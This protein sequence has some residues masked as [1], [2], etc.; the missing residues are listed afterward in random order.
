VVPAYIGRRAPGGLARSGGF[1][2]TGSLEAGADAPSGLPGFLVPGRENER[3]RTTLLSTDTACVS[4]W[5]WD[6]IF[7]SMKDSAFRPSGAFQCRDFLFGKRDLDRYTQHERTR[8][9]AQ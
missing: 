5:A 9:R 4:A 8:S 2:P 7:D 6:R 1:V 3:P